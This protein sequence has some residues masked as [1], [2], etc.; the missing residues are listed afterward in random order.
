MPK[1]DLHHFICRQDNYGVLLHDGETG[2]TASIDAPEASAIEREL[3]A[4]D[5]KLSHIL[6]THHHVDHVEGNL[7]LKRKWNARIIGP[8]AEAGQIPG[9]DSGVGDGDSYDF[10]GREVQVIAT[11]G[12]TKGHIVLHLPQERLLFAGDTLFALGCGRVIEGTLGEMWASLDRLRKLP[13]DTVFHCGHEYTE[14]NARFALTIEPGNAALAARAGKIRD[15]R[16]RGEMTLPGTIGEELAT[17]V[18]LRPESKEVRSVLAMPL[19]SRA[20]VFA[21]IRKRKD[22]FR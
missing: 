4:R 12:H 15:Q 2:L 20:D 6:T 16:A 10:A 8:K 18:F 9:I 19:A 1:L 22:S 14:A 5:W 3:A 13:P 21:E 7:A 17:N 11:P